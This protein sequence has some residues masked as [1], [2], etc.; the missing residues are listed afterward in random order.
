MSGCS[1]TTWGKGL[2]GLIPLGTTGESPTVEDDE[3]DAIVELTIST[4]GN[5]LPIYVGVGGNSTS[6]VERTTERLE[7]YPFAG[8]L[9]VC[10]YYNR[11]G[12]DG[13][14]QHFE[15]VAAAT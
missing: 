8:I 13:V 7:R 4:V 12:E 2:S 9:S 1:I 15:Q 6:K 5:R 11:P 10:P 14:R 3:V